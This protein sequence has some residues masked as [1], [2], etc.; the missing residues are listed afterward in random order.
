MIPRS[1][2]ALAMRSLAFVL[3]VLIVDSYLSGYAN[4]VSATTLSPSTT[5]T[6]VQTVST[7]STYGN[8]VNIYTVRLPNATRSGNCVV[9]AVRRDSGSAALTV[10]D[11]KGNA[12]N[13]GI[14]NDDGG[15]DV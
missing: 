7:S 13:L 6:L 10:S 8:L 4:H 1:F 12:Y 14:D 9:L 3:S 15:Q 5:P 11:D 2:F